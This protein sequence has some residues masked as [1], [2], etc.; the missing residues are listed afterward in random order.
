MRNFLIPGWSLVPRI[1]LGA[2]TT[3][4]ALTTWC[5]SPPPRYRSIFLVATA[6][7]TLGFAL[8]IVGH[9]RGPAGPS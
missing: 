2:L 4:N 5:T 7:M 8:A 3:R 6:V 1:I 9:G